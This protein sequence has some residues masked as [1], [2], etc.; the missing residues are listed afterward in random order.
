MTASRL[1][2]P[3]TS[4]FVDPP[5]SACRRKGPRRA[6]RRGSQPG[7]PVVAALLLPVGVLLA[8]QDPAALHFHHVDGREAE[9]EFSKPGSV[10]LAEVE[11][12][13]ERFELLCAN[14][15]IELHYG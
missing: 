6:S 1:L 7:H 4:T 9:G 14:C 5:P 8:S 3:G 11:R 13:P 2:W 12:Y 15:H 10:K